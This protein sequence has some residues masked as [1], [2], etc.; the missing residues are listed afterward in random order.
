MKQILSH[1]FFY[2]AFQLFMGAK[3]SRQNFVKNSVKPFIGMKILDIGCGTAD[4]LTYLPDVDYCGY[5]ISKTYIT[6]AKKKFGGLGQFY[7]KELSFNDLDSLPKFDLVIASGLI[8]HLDDSA[9]LDILKISHEALKPGGRLLTIDPCLDPKQN[10]IA[11]FLVSNDRG[12]YVRNKQ[13]YQALVGKIFEISHGQV[14]NQVWIPYTLC[15]FECKKAMFKT[16]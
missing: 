16:F 1:P 6:H 12:L 11:R 13:E 10:A 14:R 15:L 2:N 4:I 5:D 8:H 9:A 7:C 3:R